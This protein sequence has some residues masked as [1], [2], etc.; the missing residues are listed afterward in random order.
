MS[1]ANLKLSEASKLCGINVRTLKLL[2]SDELLPQVVRTPQGH[3]LLP[4]SKVPTWQE[5]RDLL[6]Q[7]RDYHLRRA[8]RLLDRVHVELEAIR[9]D[10]TEAQENPTQP[11]GVDLMSAS[12][13]AAQSTL[14]TVMQQFQVARMEIEVYHRALGEMVENDRP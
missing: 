14:S 2:I 3:P 12:T 9:N 1:N 7:R 8:T 11:L 10:I 4:E 13:F 6:K 5:C